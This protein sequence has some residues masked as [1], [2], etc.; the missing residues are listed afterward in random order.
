VEP[1]VFDIL[2]AE[3]SVASRRHIGG[4]APETVRAAIARARTRL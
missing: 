3:G 2:T 4:T 1:D